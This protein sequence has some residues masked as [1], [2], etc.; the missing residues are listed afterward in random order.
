LDKSWLQVSG[1]PVLASVFASF[2]T[3]YCAALLS[4]SDTDRKTLALFIESGSSGLLFFM[5]GY[6]HMPIL[7]LADAKPGMVLTEAVYNHQDRL[8]MGAGRRI[9]EK[10]LRVFKSWGVATVAVRGG[11]A[12]G[13]RDAAV[14]AEAWPGPDEKLAARFACVLPD[15]VMQA[16]MEAAGRQ[17][18]AHQAKKK[19]GHERI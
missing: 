3:L 2:Q 1:S 9:S 7:N 11:A 8:L 12:G 15:P 10:S 18:A 4:L 19:S 16:I 6:C 17:L 14:P 13:V 5:I